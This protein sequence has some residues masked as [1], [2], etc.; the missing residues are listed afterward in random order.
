ML[1]GS[2]EWV[3]W[4]A[5][6]FSST[7]SIERGSCERIS[8]TE[9][10]RFET[11]SPSDESMPKFAFIPSASAVKWLSI[12][13]ALM[14]PSRIWQCEADPLIL[15]IRA[16]IEASGRS[17]IME[18]V[19]WP[20][21]WVPFTWALTTCSW[22]EQG[23]LNGVFSFPPNESTSE[24]KQASNEPMRTVTAASGT[25]SEMIITG[26]LS[27]NLFCSPKNNSFKSCL[28]RSMLM[29]M[30]RAENKFP[31]TEE[32]WKWGHV[33]VT[34]DASKSFHFKE[35]TDTSNGI[36]SIE[37]GKEYSLSDVS[38]PIRPSP[39]YSMLV[40][41]NTPSATLISFACTNPSI[42]TDATKIS[43]IDAEISFPS[44]SKPLKFTAHLSH[45]NCRVSFWLP[46][47]E[48]VVL[49]ALSIGFPERST[50]ASS[51][52]TFLVPFS[53]QTDS[54]TARSSVNS[55]GSPAIFFS[56]LRPSIS[57]RTCPIIPSI[58]SPRT[59]GFFRWGCC[60]EN[61]SSSSSNESQDTASKNSSPSS[62]LVQVSVS[63]KVH[64]RKS[65][66]CLVSEAEVCQYRQ[67]PLQSISIT[68]SSHHPPIE[69]SLFKWI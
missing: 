18:S 24:S 9:N 54:I 48:P 25:S 56:T 38:S 57:M 61:S 29:S 14:Q 44:P 58:Q 36:E 60:S 15:P 32:T 35:S 40:A 34:D 53:L 47:R 4:R 16:S 68:A 66:K 7:E 50:A 65:S 22:I 27:I 17:V 33:P 3:T 52:L 19:K 6:P 31:L 23:S 51:K 20:L 39:K 64:R 59:P 46:W 21:N 37:K 41:V 42:I 28:L 45:C 1:W 5:K 63:S 62:W 13:T 43:F 30:L 2:L 11:L 55:T 12:R 67:R 49:L 26:K 69:T 8:L 10:G